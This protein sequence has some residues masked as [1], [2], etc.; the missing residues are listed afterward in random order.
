MREKRT[1]IY[2]LAKVVIPILLKPLFGVRIIG[3][4]MSLPESG[5]F[6]VCCNH[7]SNLDPLWLMLGQKRQMHFMAKEELF[8]KAFPRFIVGGFGA[9]AVKRGAA[10][11]DAIN[12]AFDYLKQERVLGIFPEGT[13]SKNGELLP[14][15][16]GA[17]MVAFKEN[18][19]IL[20]A[21]IYT[22]GGKVKP[23]GK[24]YVKFGKP[25]TLE[26]LGMIEGK[27]KELREA[28]RRLTEKVSELKQQ[29]AEFAEGK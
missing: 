9:F 22:K 15:K 19:P 4:K 23:F 10:D 7:V 18:A 13:R 5:R 14:F 1:F 16:A 11:S 24:V 29:C 25:I 12:Q 6:V 20:P 17:A 3:G 2:N 26:E 21:A 28:T 8:K 27:G